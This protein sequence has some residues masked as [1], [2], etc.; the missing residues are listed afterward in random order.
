ME[1]S[2]R[3]FVKFVVGGLGGTLL[4]PLPWKLIDD[5]A[6][7]T[8]NWSWVSVPARGRFS[9][10]NTV[11]TLCPGACGIEVRKVGSRAVKIEGRGD[12]PVNQGAICPLGMAGL[13]ILYNEGVRWK[14]PMK[15]LG[16]R[17]SEEWK[18]ISWD[19][20][21]DELATRIKGLRDKGNPEKLAA[22]DG[23]QSRS[24]IALLIK[25]LLNSI[26]SPNY[27]GMPAEEDTHAMV[28]FLMQGGKGPVA[29]DL[30]NSDFI[31]N[32]GC[33]LL[34]GWGAPGR[35]LSLWRE[36]AR[37]W[38][39]NK[40][41]L[42]Q[43]E[44][45][46]SNTASKADQW[47]APLPGT[48]AALALGIAHV[49]IEERLYSREFIENHSLGFTE[50]FDVSGARHKGFSG[51]V[52]ENY[53]PQMVEDITGVGSKVIID[54]A[55]RF[56]LAKAPIALAGR[57]KGRL[58][59]SLY[60]FMAVHALNALVGRVNKKGGVLV[61]N[62]LPLAQWSEVEYDPV[63]TDGLRK[64][65]V[66]LAGTP[67]YPFTRSLIHRFTDVIHSS[68]DSPIDTLLIFSANPVYAIPEGQDFLKAMA[69]IPFIVS[70][71]PF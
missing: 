32:F 27:M 44:P 8:Q 69:R 67:R 3:N 52:L 63:A 42:V 14:A 71:S 25:R 10:T 61:A 62:D 7:W 20:A 4:S 37:N 59:G 21:I 55:R 12:Y 30:E 48:E 2:R 39:K 40:T 43:I 34:D 66:D 9:S 46:A 53:S 6:I 24:T 13:Q 16:S 41:Y 65:R 47:L 26:G 56:A 28:N 15:R 58:P 45:R 54:V 1:F 31:L 11:C 68:H 35:M 51:V 18:E 23:N 17:G 5:I 57:G 33:S 19:E 64:E 22:I 38:S 60:E 49:L 29:F 36:R 50:W 70:F